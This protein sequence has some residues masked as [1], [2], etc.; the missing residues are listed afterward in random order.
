MRALVAA[1]LFL[2]LGSLAACEDTPPTKTTDL[3]PPTDFAS[4]P[5]LARVDLS[6][7]IEFADF[8]LGLINT[9]TSDT[10]LPTTTE[11]KVFVDAMD[12][13]KFAPLFP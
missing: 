2:G 9:Q 1:L 8:V 11:D 7:P 4:G 3:G 5:D 6:A 12:P 13:L 10:T